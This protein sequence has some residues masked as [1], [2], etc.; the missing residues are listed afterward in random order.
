MRKSVPVLFALLGLTLLFPGCRGES[1]SPHEAARAAA[2]Q[3]YGYLIE[4]EVDKYVEAIHDYD[5]LSESYRSQLR[6]M[7]AQYLHHEQELRGGLTAAH[8][9]RD[10]IIDSLQAHVFVELVF[11]DSTREE[12]SL[13]LVLTDKGWKLR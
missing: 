6:D 4:G 9:L 1:L 5:S 2:E 8:A 12:V 3:Y 7:F 13:P 11:G 10:T